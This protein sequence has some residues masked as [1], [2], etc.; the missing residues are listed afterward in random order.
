MAGYQDEV[1]EVLDAS[2]LAPLAAVRGR[3]RVHLLRDVLLDRDHGERWKHDAGERERPLHREDVGCKRRRFDEAYVERELLELAPRQL[4]G[5]AIADCVK[6]HDSL[7][8]RGATY[9]EAK[10]VA[11][12]ACRRGRQVARDC[13]FV[14]VACE[15]D[16]LRHARPQPETQL[17]R[18]GSLQHPLGRRCSQAG[19]EALER[20]ALAQTHQRYAGRVDLVAQA[21]LKRHAHRIG[22][23]VSHRAAAWSMAT[24]TRLATRSPRLSTSAWSCSASRSP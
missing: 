9:A 1:D 2:A 14:I 13:R 15:V 10:E 17:E 7:K 4:A 24:R 19:E 6:A 3:V 21:L 16:V 11:G 5:D 23:G 12:V 20:D 8:R 18:E 22:V